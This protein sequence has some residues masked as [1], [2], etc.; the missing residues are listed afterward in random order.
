MTELNNIKTQLRE[1]IERNLGK[2]YGHFMFNPD[3]LELLKVIPEPKEG[4]E[5]KEFLLGLDS[6]KRFF[7]SHG[8]NPSLLTFLDELAFSIESSHQIYSYKE[9]EDTI[10][11]KELEQFCFVS[12]IH[13]EGMVGISGNHS[14]EQLKAISNKVYANTGSV[15]FFVNEET[16]LNGKIIAE[17]YDTPQKIP[18]AFL[19][20]KK[21]T[22]EGMTEHKRVSLFGEKIDLKSYIILKEVSAD[23]RVYRFLSESNNQEYLLMA[24][25]S[26]RIGDYKVKGVIVQVND[27]KMVTQSSKLLT[28]LPYLFANSCSSRISIYKSKEEFLEK[29]KSLDVSEKNLY[30]MPFTL[31]SKRRKTYMIGVHPAWFKKLIWSF[32]LHAPF[33]LEQEY[34]MHVMVMGEPD[35][36]KSSLHDSLHRRLGERQKVFSGVSSTLKSLIPSFKENPAKVGHLAMCQRFAFCDEFLRCIYRTRGGRDTDN[37]DEGMGMMNDLLVWQKREAGSGNSAINVNMTARMLATS[38]PVRGSKN[39]T[40]ML[41][42]FDL[43]NLSR[44]LICYQS[45][46]H[47]DMVK[48]H[49]G[50]D[51]RLEEYNYEISVNDF[52]SM[53]DYLHSFSSDFDEDKVNVVYESKKFIL[54]GTLLDHYSARHKHH[55]SCLMDGLV[56]MRCLF[57]QDVSFKA[58]KED[59]DLLDII[60]SHIITS[61]VGNV[62]V[63]GL[64]VGERVKYMPETAQI[65]FEKVCNYHTR[66]MVL[67]IK[68]FR[69]KMELKF[70]KQAFCENYVLLRDNGLINESGYNLLPYY[71]GYS[72]GGKL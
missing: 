10:N 36:G 9:P 14:Y 22:E 60:W 2:E 23:L 38:N 26:L 39:M 37:R 68:G 4:V 7:L 58:K 71:A 31:W 59:Y 1:L 70:G 64:P 46:E 42:H 49:D 57:E 3:F 41:E 5:K 20:L 40:E 51:K 28:K 52:L 55:I 33:G 24:R 67:D 15:N 43:S 21:A 45:K 47:C 48:E 54:S 34:P 66:E 63:K 13:D 50:S 19:A 8:L 56:K 44:M 53:I 35:S 6:L 18:V 30:D 69:D 65:L 29:V 62:D 32:M 11:D 72:G 16:I 25:E 12:R 17:V 61:W 27:L